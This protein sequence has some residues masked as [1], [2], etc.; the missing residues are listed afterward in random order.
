MSNWSI[1]GTGK[2]IY[3]DGSYEGELLR[4]K[5]SREGTLTYKNGDKFTGT[6]LEDTQ[7]RGTYN[8]SKEKDHFYEGEFKNGV[9]EGKGKFHYASGGVYTGDIKDG[10]RHG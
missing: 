5:K 7:L 9:M 10:K 1:S 3:I 8:Y 2:R 4:D 6:W